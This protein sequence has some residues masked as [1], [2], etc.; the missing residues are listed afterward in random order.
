MGSRISYLYPST[1]SRVT[2]PTSCSRPDS[3]ATYRADGAP[4]K[5]YQESGTTTPSP[6]VFF[7]I[8]T[9]DP[10][11]THAF[12][13]DLFDWSAP[14]P[15]L[16]VAPGS[17]GVNP[18]GPADFDVQG[19]LMPPANSSEGNAGQQI[20]LYFRVDNLEA[21][22]PKAEKLGA[23]IVMPITQISEDGPHIA[24]IR[25]PD[26]ELTVGIVQA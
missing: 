23:A 3:N 26:D 12:L 4:F 17:F 2:S 10:A 16:P 11:R 8:A 5:S 24:V 22:I 21:T 9:S 18:G 19:Q 20:T 25:T 13:D 14:N 1:P 6:L 7:Q 15:D